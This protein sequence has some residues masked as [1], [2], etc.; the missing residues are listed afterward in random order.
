MKRHLLITLSGLLLS[1]TAT[2]AQVAPDG[3]RPL[4]NGK[5]LTGWDGNPALW[6]VED[7]CITGKTAGPQTLTYDQF[8]IWPAAW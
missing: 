2:H 8:L 4:F 1:L 6:S 3:F 5:D 7:G